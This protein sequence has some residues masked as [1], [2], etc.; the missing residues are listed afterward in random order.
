MPNWP[1]LPPRLVQK[2]LGAHLLLGLAL[3][4]LLYIVSITGVVA[5]FAHELRTWETPASP[6]MH[7]VSSEDIDRALDN[8]L[9]LSSPL[10]NRINIYLPTD[11]T[12][13]FR[14][15]ADRAEIVLDAEGNVQNSPQS[16]WTDFVVGLH[17]QL[18]LPRIL[19]L[20]VVG[21]VGMLMLAS[22]ISGFLAHPKILRDAF[23]FRVSGS[24]RLQQADIH[25]RLSVW[26]SPF[27]IAIAFSGAVLGLCTIV[28]VAIAPLEY[29]GNSG[30]VFQTIFGNGPAGA[31]SGSTHAASQAFSWFRSEHPDLEPDMISLSSPGTDHQT[32]QILAR[33]PRRLISGEYYYFS[34]DGTFTGSA[35]VSDGFIGQ[36]LMSSM[37]RLH[38][39]TFGGLTIKWIYALL[40]L[41]LSVIVATGMNIYFMKRQAA[42]RS[43]LKLEALWTSI[44]WG[45]PAS[46]ACGFLLE[47]LWPD[48]G[49]LLVMQFW[50]LLCMISLATI[51]GWLARPAFRLR[52]LTF[53]AIS[54]GVGQ[55]L[56]QNYHHLGKSPSL[57]TSGTLL[58]VAVC[59]LA[60]ELAGL[61]GRILHA[62]NLPDV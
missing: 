28:A 42:G 40:G 30:A 16:P 37:Y 14:L 58:A 23:I 55:H 54:V 61:F 36:Q 38:F 19:G 62:R 49:N 52:L 6:V 5:T 51:S 44:V 11:E 12:P 59:F 26:T 9:E 29:G 24:K 45:A 31:S 56:A 48:F 50:L 46:I 32:I 47:Q 4:A 17:H 35:H 1:K 18:N 41:F 13:H 22:I 20:A 3:S 60:P 25:N 43:A 8:V 53:A 39:G 2:A 33:H 15:M 7:S 10:P 34:G 21:L 27:H 57:M